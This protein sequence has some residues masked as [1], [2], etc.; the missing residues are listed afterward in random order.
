MTGVTWYFTWGVGEIGYVGE[1]KYRLSEKEK[2]QKNTRG[3]VLRCLQY[4]GTVSP[5]RKKNYT[6]HIE[7]IM[8][9]LLIVL[10]GGPGGW[11]VDH[12]NKIKWLDLLLIK[13]AAFLNVGNRKS[14]LLGEEVGA[15]E[16]AAG[17]PD[18]N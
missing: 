1:E 16:I 14:R 6:N 5:S 11:N 15:L 3:S 13:S 8:G 10:V 17:V 2:N 12:S 7:N 9:Y 18:R 4:L